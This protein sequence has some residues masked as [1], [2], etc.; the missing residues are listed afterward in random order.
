MSLIRLGAS[1]FL[2]GELLNFRGVTT[3][4]N[5]LYTLDLTKKTMLTFYQFVDDTTTSSIFSEICCT[6]FFS[7]NH[8][9]NL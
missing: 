4:W 9:A 1:L 8:K 2:G 7:K 6:L 3:C 5:D